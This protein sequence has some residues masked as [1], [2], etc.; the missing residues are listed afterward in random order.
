M[1]SSRKPETEPIGKPRRDPGRI[2]AA[3]ATA[4]QA[5]G[6]TSEAQ[7]ERFEQWRER[8]NGSRHNLQDRLQA[9]EVLLDALTDERHADAAVQSGSPS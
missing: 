7:L 3:Q 9:L 8:W 2:P 5:E 1:E 4:R 6:A